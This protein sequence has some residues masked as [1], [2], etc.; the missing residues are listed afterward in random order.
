MSSNFIRRHIIAIQPRQREREWDNERQKRLQL[1][2]ITK[3]WHEKID[4][5]MLLEMEKE[6]QA[7]MMELDNP[8]TSSGSADSSKHWSSDLP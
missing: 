8:E 1:K 2:N 7:Y 4:P 6:V 5:A 3:P